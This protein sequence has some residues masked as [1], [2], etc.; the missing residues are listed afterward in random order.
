MLF[1]TLE[2]LRKLVGPWSFIRLGAGL[3][4]AQVY[5]VSSESACAPS[6]LTESCTVDSDARRRLCTNSYGG[7]GPSG[8]ARPTEPKRAFGPRGRFPALAG[9]A[10]TSVGVSYEA[11]GL[12][13][14][15]ACDHQAAAAP[16]RA[17]TRWSSAQPRLSEQRAGRPIRPQVPGARPRGQGEGS[18]FPTMTVGGRAARWRTACARHAARPLVS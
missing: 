13:A 11:S 12:A 4:Q 14:P 6:S 9:C 8:P 16:K 18:L 10:Q 5:N 17:G 1:F 15:R 7:E 3:D 2:H